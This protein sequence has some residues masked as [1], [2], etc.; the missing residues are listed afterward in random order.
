MNRR[1]FLKKSASTFLAVYSGGFL[2]PEI[3]L[4][5]DQKFWQR[6]RTLSIYRPSSKER[7]NIKF[8]ADGH[9]IQDGYKALCWM[10]RDVVDNNAMH[11]IN[12]NLINLLFAQ[13]Q[14]LRDSGRSN[15]EIV[16][17]S[18]FRTRRHNQTLEGAAYN[19]KH[20][21]GDAGDYHIEGASLSELVMLARRFKAGGIGS[22][23]T[24]VHNDIGRYR[25][26][27]R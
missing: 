20:L 4:A 24:F 6:A 13:Q 5:D 23:S 17:H 22:Y 19:S 3:A 11:R 16:L 21:T 27:R 7:R 12:I 8:F 25:E 9:Y 15:T 2:L 10:M 26:W 18:G 14:Y 1:D